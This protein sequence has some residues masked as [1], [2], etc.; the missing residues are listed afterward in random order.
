M[1]VGIPESGD[2]QQSCW[3]R[4]CG[5]L[6]FPMCLQH[7]GLDRCSGPGVIPSKSSPPDSR[8]PQKGSVNN[9]AGMFRSLKFSFIS[10]GVQSLQ[11]LPSH[12]VLF[13]HGW[14]NSV[15]ELCCLQPDFGSW[16]GCELER[17]A[18]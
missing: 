8:E 13:M 3:A 9:L 4:Y 2:A 15:D 10:Q 5:G 6:F 11:S 1:T 16:P 18:G 14:E 12:V 17:R 7:W